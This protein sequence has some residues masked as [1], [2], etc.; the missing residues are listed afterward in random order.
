MCNNVQ[1]TQTQVRGERSSEENK[2]E[3]LKLVFYWGLVGKRRCLGY[4]TGKSNKIQ[5]ILSSLRPFLMAWAQFIA[6]KC[7]HKFL[8][9]YAIRSSRS[10]F[11]LSSIPFLVLILYLSGAG[12]SD[13]K[14]PRRVKIMGNIKTQQKQMSWKITKYN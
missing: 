2:S 1:P 8:L 5:E 13:S 12:T 3:K 4:H 9:S 6:G 10:D 7:Y 14:V 11:T